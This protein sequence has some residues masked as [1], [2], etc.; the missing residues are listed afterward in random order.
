[1]IPSEQ[2][3]T[4]VLKALFFFFCNLRNLDKWRADGRREEYFEAFCVSGDYDGDSAELEALWGQV[5]AIGR[6]YEEDFLPIT[7]DPNLADPETQSALT[8]KFTPLLMREFELS[9]PQARDLADD[10]FSSFLMS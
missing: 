5:N 10:I 1:M 2:T 8:G 6:L 7:E 3:R 4:K 9:A